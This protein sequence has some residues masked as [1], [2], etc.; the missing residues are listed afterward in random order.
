MI[1]GVRI[2]LK[3]NTNYEMITLLQILMSVLYC[4][5]VFKAFYG[6]KLWNAS[7]KWGLLC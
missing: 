2:I 1:D 6:N 5:L 7:Y 4:T 3:Y